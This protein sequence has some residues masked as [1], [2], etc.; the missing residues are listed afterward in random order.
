MSEWEIVKVMRVCICGSRSI[1]D[2][3]SVFHYLNHLTADLDLTRV[4]IISGGASGVD[5]LAEKWASNKGIPI[6]RFLPDW[7]RYGKRAGLIRNHKMVEAS[8]LIIALWDGV[9]RGTAH[10]IITAHKF[11]KLVRMKIIRTEY[12]SIWFMLGKSDAICVTTNGFVVRD[13]KTRKPRGVMG[14]GVAYQAK[15]WLPDIEY[16]LGKHLIHNGNCPGIL[17][18]VQETAIVSFPVKRAE[19]QYP[20]ELVSHARNRF[21]PGDLVPGYL[22]KADLD[23]ILKSANGLAE[24][25]KEYKWNR[26][27]LPKPGCGAGE[28][29]WGDVAKIIKKSNL[30]KYADRI[31]IT[32]LNGYECIGHEL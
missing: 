16:R 13:K 20:C 31:W 30:A 24:L 4:T 17:G 6:K 8:D 18:K 7:Y 11:N 29:K 22:L 10:T 15:V 9:S 19:D 1:T 28:L 21:L 23:T 27:V 14:R 26:I 2:Q 5:R 32:D 25:I 3:D 12:F